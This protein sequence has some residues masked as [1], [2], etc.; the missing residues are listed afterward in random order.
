MTVGVTPSQADLL[1][2]TAAF[3]AGRVGEESIWAV[4]HRDGHRLYGDEL[5]A[6]LFAD[7]GRRSV[8]PSIV[9]TEVGFFDQ[10]HFGRHFKRAV[11]TTPS[12]YLAS[13]G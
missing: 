5:F 11:G 9:A 12:A 2:G 8:P 7:S 10:S 3:C 6:D 13:R 1:K 4:L